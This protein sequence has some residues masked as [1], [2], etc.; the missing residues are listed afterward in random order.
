MGQGPDGLSP[1]LPATGRVCGLV[2]GMHRPV[3][4]LPSP[5]VIDATFEPDALKLGRLQARH[6]HIRFPDGTLI[7]TDNADDLPPVLALESGSQDAV[8][9]LALPLLRA[10]GGNCLT[11]DAVA[12]RPVRYRQRWRDIRNAFGDDTRQIAVM[13]PELTLRFTCQDNSDYLTCPVARPQQDSQGA[14]LLDETFLPPLL[15]LQGSRWLMTQLEQLMSQLRVRLSRLYGMNEGLAILD[16]LL[17]RQWDN[18]WPQPVHARM[19]ILSA[20]SRRLQ[21]TMRT[22]TLTCIDL[23]Q[24]YQ[25]EEHLNALGDILQRLELRHASQLDALRT[26]VHNA[27]VRLENSDGGQEAGGAVL[28]ASF[29]TPAEHVRWVY[30]AQPEPLPDRQVMTAPP[31]VKPW[32]P[33][34]AGMATMLV[35][36]SSVAWGWQTM[37]T[38]DPAQT[39]LDATLAP[40][41]DELSKA[42]LQA[43]RQASLSPVAGLS[44]TQNRLAQLRELKPDWAWRYGDSLVQQALILWPQEAKP[45]AQ[46]WQQQVNVAALPQ[47]YLAGWHQGMTQLQQLANRLNAL[48]EH[49]GK[50]MTVS[51]LKS[52][53]FTMMQAFNSAV[54]AEEQLRQLA[55]LPENQPWPA[56]QQSQTEQHLQQLI[57]RYALMK[58]K[59]AE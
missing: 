2:C 48:D 47:P 35:I 55:D 27:A 9:V 26:Q 58:Q 56:A 54:P 21:Q 40:L 14:W 59:T 3:R 50:Y 7:D 46:Q 20:L 52:A 17:S 51:E 24:L 57:A 13:K 10:N 36:A 42:Q 33:F 25:T 49:R 12:E 41:P 19:E 45:L 1:A 22:L 38:P 16:A 29:T 15:A 8:V 34:V 32:K 31:P 4:S 53:V 30:V 23:S 5:G 44:K 6:L 43:L 28:P 37:H 18:I 11:P 39:Q